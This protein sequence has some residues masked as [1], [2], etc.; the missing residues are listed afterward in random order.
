MTMLCLSSLLSLR[1]SAT[2]WAQ[3][4]TFAKVKS[5]A[6]IPRHPSVPNLIG[7]A[8]VIYTLHRIPNCSNQENFRFLSKPQV[9]S[10]TTPFQ[11]YGIQLR[12]RRVCLPSRAHMN[13][14]RTIEDLCWGYIC[15]SSPQT[16]R[17]LQAVYYRI[18]EHFP[19]TRTQEIVLC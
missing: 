15:L 11:F 7:L 16:L 4:P 14:A 10:K 3:I 2:A 12:F 5:S 13:S 1:Y 17:P 19:D 9:S 6:I 8:T 18:E